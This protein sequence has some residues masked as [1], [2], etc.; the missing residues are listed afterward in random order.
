MNKMKRLRLWIYLIGIFLGAGLASMVN[1]PSIEGRQSGGPPATFFTDVPKHDLDVVLARPTTTSVTMSLLAYK[2][3]DVSLAYEP[4]GVTRPLTLRQG[5]PFDVELTDLEP[6]QAYQYTISAGSPLTT[7][8][9][10]TARPAG[11]EFVFAMQADSHLD[12][13]TDVKI[14]ANTLANI[15]ADRPDFLIDLGDTF[16]TD[17]YPTYQESAAQYL[18]QRYYLGLAGRTMPVFLTLGNHDG[19]VGWTTRGAAEMTAW[20]SAMRRKYFPP[21]QS[22]DFYTAGPLTRNY[23]AWTWGDA[24]FIVLDPFTN[25][26]IKPGKNRDGWGWTLGQEQ[27]TWLRA[28]LE[29]SKAPFIFVF[30]HHLV[31]G[32]GKEARGGAE[33]SVYFEWGGANADGTPGFA[34]NRPGWPMPIHDL[35]VAYKVS[36]VFHGHDH[37]YV[38]QER[39][40]I[41]YQEVPQ[42]GFARGEATGSADDY[43]YVSGTLLSSSGHVR[44]TVSSTKATVDYVKSRLTGKNAEIVDQYV[45]EPAPA[46]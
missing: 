16:M 20:S 43:G 5:V 8:T 38:H 7:G 40:G 21:V 6:N 36:A 22:D 14:Y 24:Q 31:G 32:N 12:N 15:V 18:A 27:Y 34:A 23:Y 26:Q 25:T 19:E 30:I 37:L 46:R 11:S 42:P 1:V 3:L 45:L 2:D 10:R 9:F 17:K 41:A 33:A 28:T 29:T 39:D 35:L 4:G 44:V 13:N